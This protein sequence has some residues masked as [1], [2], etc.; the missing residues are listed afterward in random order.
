MLS[1]PTAFV[2]SSNLP[3]PSK[4]DLLNKLT[5]SGFGSI[6][7]NFGA[8]NL[9]SIPSSGGAAGY[10]SALSV[11]SIRPPT[12]TRYYTTPDGG[13]TI[14]PPTTENNNNGWTTPTP[15]T[16]VNPVQ[17]GDVNPTLERLLAE[18]A[19][20]FGGDTAERT[21]GTPVVVVPQGAG[22]DSGSAAPS[23][24][25]KLLAILALAGVGYLGYRWYKNRGA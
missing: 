20:Q 10:T 9:D 19:N 15:G 8:T 6:G 1:T 7:K 24:A 17:S 16:G 5:T 12:P 18:Y 3:G 11:T 2:L 21:S 14:T 25:P 22:S 23:A 4:L 13:S